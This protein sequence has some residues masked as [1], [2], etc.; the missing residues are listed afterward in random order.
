MAL[1][2]NLVD[3][4]VDK[5]KKNVGRPG[6]LTLDDY[7]IE[8]INNAQ[9]KVCNTRNFWWMWK[10]ATI[11]YTQG[12]NAEALPDRF[13]DE[14]SVW[15]EIIEGGTTKW[16]ELEHADWEDLRTISTSDEARPTK[17]II[18]QKQLVL[19]PVPD[20]A[21]TVRI[22]YWEY[23]P[24]LVEAGDDTSYLLTDYP[25]ILEAWATHKAFLKLR[26]FQEATAWKTQFAMELQELKKQNVERVLPNELELKF[27]SGARGSNYNKRRR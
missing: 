8:Y 27:R 22:D 14:D 4:L 23:L 12:D 21:Y 15:L 7:V 6:D 10:T 11:A 5:V 25:E 2:S 16:S 17:W 18:D 24:D 9:K 3:R 19:Y 20:D 26:E 13:K 1:P